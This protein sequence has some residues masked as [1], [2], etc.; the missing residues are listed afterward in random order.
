MRLIEKEFDPATVDEVVHHLEEA[1]LI[2]D[3]RFARAYI[4]DLQLRKPSGRR[5]LQRQLRLR[6]IPPA[7]AEEAIGEAISPDDERRAA[8]ETAAALLK[9]YRSSRKRPEPGVQQRR[10]AQ[11][12]AHR[13]FSWDVILP[14]MNKVFS[15][16]PALPLE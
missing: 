14:V 12:L 1:G 2:D 13:G 6:G 7:L 5:F 15:S 9:R 11:F 16:S 10:L 8:M 4:H 3:R